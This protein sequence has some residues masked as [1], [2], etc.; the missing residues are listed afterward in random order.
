MKRSTFRL[1]APVVREHPLQKQIAST[2]T[3]ELAPPG[4]VSR[5]GVCWW[6]ID[7]AN[8]A[9]EV[10]GVRIGRGIIAGIPDT[11]VL[12]RGIAHVIEI[13]AADGTLSDAQ[14][15]VIAAIL[16]SGG[17]AGVARDATEVLACI[18]AWSIP[19]N[20]RVREPL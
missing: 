6:S 11:F 13:K 1:T 9:G 8:Y 10:P 5:F 15:S 18:D 12:F 7:H 4:K 19:R 20:R 2:L 3:I 17:R 14:R 16:A